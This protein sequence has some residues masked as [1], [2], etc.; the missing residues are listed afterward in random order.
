LLASGVVLAVLL[1]VAALVLSIIGVT[2]GAERQPPPE[3]RK[4]APQELFVDDADKALCEAIGPLMKQS[5]ESKQ[6]YQASGTPGSP[7]RAAAIPKFKSDTL[8]WAGRIQELLNAHSEP[9]RYL[10]RTLQEYI[11]GMLLYTENIYPDRQPDSFDKATWDSAVVAYGGPLGTC[12]KLG[13]L[14]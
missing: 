12:Q 7:E 5:D 1:G 11:D 4:A 8:N 3:T 6:A 9:P 10:T 2:R 13:A 14:W